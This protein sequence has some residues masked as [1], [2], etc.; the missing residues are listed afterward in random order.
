M[1]ILKSTYKKILVALVA[2]SWVSC[3]SPW[4]DRE[5]SNDPNLNE[6]LNEAIAATPETTTFSQLL[7]QSGYDKI[8]EAS[9][10][11][12]VFAPTNEAMQLV[13]AAIINNPETL[14][15]FVANH[16]TL[17]AYP[18]VRKNEIDRLQMLSEK[19]L[20]F[21]GTNTIGDAQIVS[22]DHYAAN[23]IF[24]VVN[25]AL[26][27]KLNIWEFINSKKETSAMSAFLVSLNDF[28]IYPEDA[29]AKETA[30][31]GMYADSL[32][33]SYLKNVYNLNNEKNEYTFFMMEDEG[34]NAEVDVMKK[35]LTKTTADSTATYAS[36]FTLRDMALPKAYTKEQLPE[37][38]VSRF[39]VTYKIDKTQIVGEPVLMSNGVLYIMKK[40][41][42]ALDK[43]L[44]PTIIEGESTKRSSNYPDFNYKILY[45]DKKDPTLGA[46]NNGFFKDVSVRSLTVAKFT[47]GYSAKDFY[48]TTYKVYWRAINDFDSTVFQQ[49]LQIGRV[50]SV[51]DNTNY[52]SIIKTF[53]YVPV[54]RNNF[55]EVY[56]GE[57][58]LTEARDLQ[59]ILL[60]GNNSTGAGT[61][62]LTLDYLKFEPVIK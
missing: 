34:Y 2:I 54:E 19:Y 49:Q 1:T 31:A 3:S 10:S 58:T 44:V 26:G 56:I 27:P 47:L 14:K 25:K 40:V 52:V 28:S 60:I 21:T 6:N 57:F 50:T 8:L 53:D 11:Y 20:N 4:D 36:Y 61:N 39:G 35:Y 12:T 9:K 13:D 38:I 30:E 41:E 42:V 17:S 33:N 15:Q 23:G 5:G 18:S 37:E 59:R 32:S 7:I 48:S 55:K 51:V 43:R 24:H 29:E 46:P 45:R 62:S 22:S 16:I